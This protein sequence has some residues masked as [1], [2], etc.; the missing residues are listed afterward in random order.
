[1]GKLLHLQQF[2]AASYIEQG[3]TSDRALHIRAMFPV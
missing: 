1:M 3:K 2:I